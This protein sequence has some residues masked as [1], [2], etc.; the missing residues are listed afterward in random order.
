MTQ[1]HKDKK[2]DGQRRQLK[3]QKRKKSRKLMQIVS[4]LRDT[5]DLRRTLIGKIQWEWPMDLATPIQ[6]LSNCRPCS[7]RTWHSRM[8]ETTACSTCCRYNSR[9]L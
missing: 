7:H 5:G 3:R 9:L 2:R 4:Y 6:P 8:Y 1:K